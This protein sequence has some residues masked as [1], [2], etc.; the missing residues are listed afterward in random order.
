MTVP[1]P[2]CL[3]KIYSIVEHYIG[4]VSRYRFVRNCTD[5]TAVHIAIPQALT[6]SIASAI[7]TTASKP[8]DIQKANKRAEQV[9]KARGFNSSMHEFNIEVALMQ[10]RRRHL[11]HHN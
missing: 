7:A 4:I 10:A 5:S 3:E 2:D 9:V 8:L 11:K 1:S 6:A